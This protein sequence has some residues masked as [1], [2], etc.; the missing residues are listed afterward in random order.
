M[1]YYRGHKY[2]GS[3]ERN[4]KNGLGVFHYSDGHV[5]EGFWL[6]DKRLVCAGVAI[7]FD[8]LCT[9]LALLSTFYR[10]GKGK[11]I[12]NPGSV[13]EENYDGDWVDDLKHGVGTYSYRADEGTSVLLSLFL[14]RVDA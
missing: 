13:V 4:K 11:I 6:D 14:L 8:L 3:W 5:Y 9:T 2:L 12:Y 10:H 1:S 7:L